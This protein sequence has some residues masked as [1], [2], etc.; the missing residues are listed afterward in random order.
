M[1]RMSVLKS[2]YRAAWGARRRLVLSYLLLLIADIAATGVFGLALRDL[3][4]FTLRNDVPDA[5]IA[6]GVASLCWVITAAGSSARM[7]MAYLLAESVSVELDERILELVGRRADIEHLENPAYVDQL[8]LLRGGGDLLAHYALGALDIVVSLLRLGVVLMILALVKPALLAI[9]LLL[10]PVLWLQRLGA[11]RVAISMI[12]TAEDTRLA[13]HLF[14]LHTDPVSAMEMRIADARPV[15]QER[16]S[17]VWDRL[18]RRQERARW[19]T[20]GR[21]T[22]AWAA[23]MVGYGVALLFIAQSVASG[24]TDPGDVLLVVALTMSLRSQAEDT[25]RTLQR[26]AEGVHFLDAY[27]ALQASASTESP[28]SSAF[29]PLRLSEGVTFR[30]VS[31]A[32]PG[33]DVPVLKDLDLRLPAG[34]TVAIVGEHG[35]G[36]TTLVKLL[37]KLYE[38]TLGTITVD[39]VPLTEISAEDWRGRSTASFQDFARFAWEVRESVGCGDLPAVHDLARIEQA[40]SHADATEIVAGL[41]SQF[42]TQLGGLFG[43]TELSGGQWQ[44]IALG[45]AFMRVSPILFVLDEPTA[46]LD[47]RSE[48]VVYQRQMAYG[49]QLAEANGAITV[50]ISHRFSTVRMADH[51]IVLSDGAVTETGNHKELM[52]LGGRYADLY[53]LQAHGYRSSPAVEEI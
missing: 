9:A 37:C 46:S 42:E 39:G 43:G 6:A 35:A 31:F 49:R 20:A 2:L 12:T 45:R 41:P 27:L 22:A 23:F 38:P 19:A 10:L 51:I 8:T 11:K 47:A 48:Y 34:A 25:V 36:K 16:T 30:G 1:T 32:Y 28:D 40:V 7:N 26:T 15:L 5:L 50:V 3:I 33:T 44:R 29:A 14:A 13:D 4:R 17:R 52:A 53:N 21:S 18:I 24:R